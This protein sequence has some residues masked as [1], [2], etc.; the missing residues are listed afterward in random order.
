[1]KTESNVKKKVDGQCSVLNLS[2]T[3]PSRESF[4]Y[5]QL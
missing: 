1:M 5:F 3:C 4:F 2:L